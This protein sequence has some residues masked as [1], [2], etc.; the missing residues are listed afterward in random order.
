MTAARIIAVLA[1][2]VAS[3]WRNITAASGFT[4][5]AQVR[6]VGTTLQFRGSISPSS[7][8]FATG[9]SI[10]IVAAGGSPVAPSAN[11]NAA[12][13]LSGSSVAGAATCRAQIASDG[14]I[15]IFNVQTTSTAVW[16][17]GVT[18]ST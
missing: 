4:S 6:Q 12:V 14:S 1:E 11:R 17:D 13:A 10:G 8:S 7:G 5:A 16:L 15:G 2:A 3:P 18:V 9:A